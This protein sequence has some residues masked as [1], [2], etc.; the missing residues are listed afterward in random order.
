MYT[1]AEAL[2]IIRQGKLI[3]KFIATAYDLNNEAFVIYVAFIDKNSNI[4]P[5]S[6]PWI[7]FV[8]A[9]EISISVSFKYTNFI[10]VFFKSLV[11][12]LLKYIAI[13]DH[14]IKLV[15]ASR[16]STDLFIS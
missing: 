16:H 7:T 13:N 2:P 9:D 10:D 5:L 3:R 6:R 14:T 12:K 8:K 1:I 4:Y 11:A 15:E